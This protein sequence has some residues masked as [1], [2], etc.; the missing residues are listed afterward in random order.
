MVNNIYMNQAKRKILVPYDFSNSS[1]YAVKHAVQIAK[2]TDSHI[3]FLHVVDNLKSEAEAQK[4][5]EEAANGFI[6]K[7]GVT[8]ESKIR[9]GQVMTAIRT[10]AQTIDAFVIIM[11]TQKPKGKEK[12]FVKVL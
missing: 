1:D 9:P 10:F 2:I 7:Y 4:N 8:I 11:K 5:L 6:S 3:V 12:Y